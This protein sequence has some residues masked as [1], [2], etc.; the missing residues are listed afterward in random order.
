M[1]KL[2]PQPKV[3][4]N[5]LGIMQGLISNN[6]AFESLH[7]GCNLIKDLDTPPCAAA[8]LFRKKNTNFQCFSK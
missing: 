8:A 7:I 3:R 2:G 5:H 6:T 4:Q 1:N